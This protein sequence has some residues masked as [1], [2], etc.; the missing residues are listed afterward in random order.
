MKEG[1]NERKKEIR[2]PCNMC[3]SVVHTIDPAVVRCSQYSEHNNV[4]TLKPQWHVFIP[5]VQL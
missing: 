1:K 5:Q 4:S 2:R 3:V